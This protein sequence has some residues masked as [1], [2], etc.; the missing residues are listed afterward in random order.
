[1]SITAAER[2]DPAPITDEIFVLPAH[3][4]EPAAPGPRFGEMVWDLRPF[5]RRTSRRFHIDF[6]GLPDEIAIRTVKEYLYSRLRRV[7]PGRGHSGVRAAMLPPSG[8]IGEFQTF[9]AVLAA[10]RA[11]GAP[12]LR[13][14]TRE[15]LDA[16]RACW[17]S[18]ETA[19]VY[20]CFL[21]NLA[22]HSQFLTQDRLT[23]YPWPGRTAN[24][25]AGRQ[26]FDENRTDRIPEAICAPLIAAAVFYVTTAGKDIMAGLREV[27][28]LEAARA[29]LDLKP[30]EA[31][32]RIRAFIAQRARQG[33]GIPALPIKKLANRPHAV[34]RDG[35]VQHANYRAVGLLA[36][37]VDGTCKR[38]GHLLTEAGREL[39]FEIGGLNTPISAWPATGAPWRPRFDPVS[40]Y[41]EIYHLRTAAWIVIAYLSGMRD[42][43]VRELH[44]DCAFTELAD[45]G[46]T[47]YKL[48]GR[49][50]KQRRLS[51][52]EADWVVLDV[53]HRAV[54]VLLLLNDDPTHLFGYHRGDEYGY[55]LLTSMPKR[56]GRFRDHL[57]DLFS[58]PAG[59]Y[60]PNDVPG[61]TDTEV[62]ADDPD[63]EP[64][65][66]VDESMPW[67]FTTR[68]FRRTLAWHIA[69]QPFGVVAGAKQYKHARHVIFSGYAGT[70][71]SGF[72]AEVAA[73][74]ATARLDYAEDLYRDWCA[75]GR[76]TGGASARID[77]EFARIRRELSD[78]PGVIAS[79]AR[80]RTM[81]AHLVKTLHPGILNDCFYQPATAVCRKQAKALGRPL[82]LHNMCLNCPNARR[83][84]I[85]LPRLLTAREQ[86]AAALDLVPAAG[87]MPPLQRAALDSHLADLD[88]VIGELH[89]SSE[90][91][92]P[93]R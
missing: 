3:L 73:E 92:D 43:E 63:D 29:R 68:Q 82:P 11:V 2:L 45:D 93:S 31:K 21:R 25:V 50:Y 5:L 30:G 59:L 4:T 10:L 32:D 39:G 28:H 74:E 52:D 40:L 65:T 54:E 8:M 24:A 79:P 17:D 91:K 64:G 56:L 53:V 37:V 44:R 80:L 15:H 16:A 87:Q 48:R 36:G 1:L 18:A 9:K 71:A 78:L 72:A 60:I 81:L 49:V 19:A 38:H 75:G 42:D 76:S 20:I 86:A 83:S 47:R 34:V 61:Q 88:Q 12:Q 89:D 67:A 41:E 7:G 22:D 85:H 33:R 35:V 90:A 14:V 46:R 62:S 58:T 70:S 26:R 27:E 13:D 66:T 23:V 57:N 6:S 69:H 84:S 55:V 77:A 51:G